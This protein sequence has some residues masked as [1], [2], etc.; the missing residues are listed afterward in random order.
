MPLA[1]DT[2]K[3]ALVKGA[4]DYPNDFNKAYYELLVVDKNKNQ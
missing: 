1:K 3:M 2:F 4:P